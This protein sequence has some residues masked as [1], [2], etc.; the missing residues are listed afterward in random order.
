MS[1]HIYILEAC[2]G[3][4]CTLYLNTDIPALVLARLV[5]DPSKLADC[6]G[7]TLFVSIFLSLKSKDQSLRGFN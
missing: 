1:L 7:M 6:L 2:R 3:H 5:F 4:L